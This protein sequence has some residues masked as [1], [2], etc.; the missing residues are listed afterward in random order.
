[1]Q[2][3]T[4]TELLENIPPSL[5][6]ITAG[7]R[8]MIMDRGTGIAHLRMLDAGPTGRDGGGRVEVDVGQPLHRPEGGPRRRAEEG[9]IYPL[10][11]L[12]RGIVVI[13]TSADETD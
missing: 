4:P 9:H 1:M 6:R 7:D 8:G 10:L 5:D 11:S 2:F 3:G 12:V 13:I